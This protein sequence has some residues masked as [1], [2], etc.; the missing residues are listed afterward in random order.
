MLGVAPSI[1]VSIRF[2]IA[3]F[4]SGFKYRASIGF[5]IK[6]FKQTGQIVLR[7]YF[8][9]KVVIVIIVTSVP[10]F[11]VVSDRPTF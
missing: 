2:S 1:I 6:K 8:I 5:L 11:W 4:Q 9:G 3:L 10:S 7:E